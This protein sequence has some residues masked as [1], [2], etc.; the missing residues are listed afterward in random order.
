MLIVILLQNVKK[1]VFHFEEN[2][3]RNIL[4]LPNH[5]II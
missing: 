2:F 4:V 3:Y 1:M 5:K